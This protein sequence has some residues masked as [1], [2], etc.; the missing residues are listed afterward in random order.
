[1]PSLMLLLAG[2]LFSCVS[3]PNVNF[4]KEKSLTRARCTETLTGVGRE[5]NDTTKLHGK[6]WWESRVTNVQMPME[7]VAELKKFV[8]KM[9]EKYPKV[10]KENNTEAVVAS[11]EKQMADQD[12]E[13]VEV[14]PKPESPVIVNPP[15]VKP[16]A[17][18]SGKWNDSYNDLIKKELIGRSI[19]DTEPARMNFC[20]KWKELSKDD[21]ISEFSKYLRGIVIFESGFKLN[22]RMVETTMG[23]DPITGRQVASEGLFQLSY[24]DGKNYP[25]CNGIDFSKDKKLAPDDLKRTIFIPEI[26][27]KCAISIMDRILKNRITENAVGKGSYGLGRYWSVVR[28]E[29]KASSIKAKMIEYK[30]K[31]F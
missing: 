6:T 29:R 8:L 23:T 19:L 10:C 1:M 12:K 21:K 16:V 14:L 28:T 27:F 5:I 25:D 7:D 30:S 31:C 17:Y 18:V 26:Q 15:V 9:C 13:P 20:P 2:S 11:L 22:S 4:C 3:M 24:Q